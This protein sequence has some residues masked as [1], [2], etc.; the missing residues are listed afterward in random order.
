MS[1]EDS[2]ESAAEPRPGTGD[3][4]QADHAADAE[5]AP[6]WEADLD[7]YPLQPSS[8]DPRWAGCIV[9]TWVCFAV[10]SII[11]IVVLLILGMSYD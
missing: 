5:A 2:N 7:E 4:V 8:Q 3:D 1:E 9:W 10:A 6:P 11:F